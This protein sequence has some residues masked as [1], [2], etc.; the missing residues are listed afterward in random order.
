MIC[1][2][3]SWEKEECSLVVT[4][5]AWG[6]LLSSNLHM[7]GTSAMLLQPKQPPSLTAREGRCL[8]CLWFSTSKG[9]VTLTVLWVAHQLGSRKAVP[10]I[11]HL[12]PPILT[13]SKKALIFPNK[14]WPLTS[15]QPDFISAPRESA[16]VLSHEWNSTPSCSTVLV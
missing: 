9:R 11:R 1:L 8:C 16:E 13:A 3:S 5:W 7:L 12:P 14:V 10:D 4:F 2:E 6:S 15:F